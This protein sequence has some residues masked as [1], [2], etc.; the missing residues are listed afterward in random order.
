[1]DFVCQ[2]FTASGLIDR[3]LAYIA[4]YRENKDTEI[5]RKE[6]LQQQKKILADKID[7]F[8]TTLNFLTERIEHHQEIVEKVEENLP[9][10][11]PSQCVAS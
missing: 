2:R 9:C 3:I 7:E 8:T 4:L 11:D 1:M 5:E 6:I 10:F